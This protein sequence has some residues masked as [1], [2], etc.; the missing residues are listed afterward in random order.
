MGTLYGKI[1]R[2]QLKTP[3]YNEINSIYMLLR[4]P[5][6]VEGREKATQNEF[7]GARLRIYGTNLD[8]PDEGRIFVWTK[9]GWFERIEGSSGNVAFTPIADSEG[10]LRELIK[11][12][13][14]STDL[15]ELGGE[16]RKMVSEEFLEQSTSYRDY[17]GP[18]RDEPNDE[19]E[20]Q[21]YHQHD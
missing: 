2:V 11:R 7:R 12:G 19:D 5:G 10:E 1:D 9:T 6:V 8:N 15:I 21:Q 18:S 17:P 13:D 16:Y 14:P 3:I 4:R 20:D